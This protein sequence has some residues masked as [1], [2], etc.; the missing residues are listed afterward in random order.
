MENSKPSRTLMSTNTKLDK[1]EKGKLVNEKLY[2][3][4]IGSLLYLTASGPNIV[5]FV[6][7]CAHFQTN[8]KESHL[9][10]VKCILKYL[11][12]SLHLGLWY[13]KKTSFDL[14]SYSDAYFA[15]SI[16]DRISIS[17]TC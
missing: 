8:P 17:G 3:G 14:C 5:F 2:R 12:G 4:I 7:L 6:Y 16:L 1:N 15:R 11:N 9:H 10:A 13:P